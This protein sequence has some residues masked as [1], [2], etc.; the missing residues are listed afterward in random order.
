VGSDALIEKLHLTKRRLP[1]DCSF[2]PLFSGKLLVSPRHATFC[3][4]PPGELGA[5]R[6]ILSGEASLATLRHLANLF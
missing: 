1:G 6:A 3:R 4:I 5:M 2:L